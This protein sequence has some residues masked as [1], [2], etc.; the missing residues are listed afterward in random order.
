MN[1]FVPRLGGIIAAACAL[2]G[3]TS[4]AT[5]PSIAVSGACC[6][7][8]GSCTVTTLQ[9][10]TLLGGVYSDNAP[11]P[12]PPSLCDPRAP[13]IAMSRTA[14][15]RLLQ[16]GVVHS[17]WTAGEAL[18]IYN[19]TASPIAEMWGLLDTGAIIAP[20]IAL[21][22]RDHPD[23]ELAAQYV[24]DKVQHAK[25][26]WSTGEYDGK[27]FYWALRLDALGQSTDWHMGPGV[28]P[29]FTNHQ[30][31]VVPG[32]L[33]SQRFINSFTDWG[34]LGRMNAVSATD[35]T[36]TVA[37]TG[38]SDGFFAQYSEEYYLQPWA[39][40]V[41][42]ESEPDMVI[43]G[44]HAEPAGGGNWTVT[45]TVDPPFSQA[46]GADTVFRV[47]RGHNND[48][49]PCYFFKNGSKDVETWMLA[50][51]A[52]LD[53]GIDFPDPV[54]VIVGTEDIGE[55]PVDWENYLDY[56][57]DARASASAEEDPFDPDNT[58]YTIDGERNLA[59]WH[60]D[61]AYRNRDPQDPLFTGDPLTY[62][63]QGAE[64]GPGN[65]D[66]HSYRGATFITAYNYHREKSTWAPLRAIWPNA[67][68]T[69]YLVGDGYGVTDPVAEEVRPV[70]VGPGES[71]YHGIPT[72]YGHMN[73]DAYYCV[74][75]AVIPWDPLSDGRVVPLY[76][77]A[78]ESTTGTVGSG[79]TSDAIVV[80][81]FG[82][83]PNSTT[84]FDP[85]WFLTAETPLFVEFTSGYNIG[86]TVVV[87][88]WAGGA[89][90]LP[91]GLDLL[92]APLNGDEFIVYYPTGVA[93]QYL[94]NNT[95]W[96]LIETFCE[97]YGE[98][99]DAAGFLATGKKWAREQ[100]RAQTLALPESAYTLTI[101]PGP[102]NGDPEVVSRWATYP[103]EPFTSKDGWLDGDDW[104]EVGSQA[105]D[106]GV[107]HF[108]WF[109]PGVVDSG[110]EPHAQLADHMVTAIGA[111]HEHHLASRLHYRE[112]WCLAD[113]NLDGFISFSDQSAFY[114]DF[115]NRMP[116]TDLNGDSDFTDADIDLF[117]SSGDCGL[118]HFV[119]CNGNNR[120]DVLDIA[121]G[122]ADPGDGF[123]DID[124]NDNGVID[125]CEPC[126][127]DWD[128]DLVVGVPDIFAFLSDWF[129]EE[130]GARCYGGT[131]GT[132]AIFAFL[133]TWFS[134]GQ[135][136]CY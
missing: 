113:W 29:A 65:A 8:N 117:Y 37:L 75:N 22:V 93:S 119:D 131:C 1:V 73:W 11:C 33:S 26:E 61:F 41:M 49:R 74:T 123:P 18:D 3:S 4:A 101:G 60:N 36:F 12:T 127:A 27:P 34:H 40:T 9:A 42:V 108:D 98:D 23:P 68:L 51:C 105:I 92:F 132:P 25:S 64:W 91:D 67:K 46:H 104:A 39:A 24:I 58:G 16:E 97:R 55:V 118:P 83:L 57:S 50:F 128:G 43:T 28:L 47:K 107:N 45:F 100:A 15:R 86:T 56:W 48:Y 89:L 87:T 44:Y 69:Q 19:S 32:K 109:V 133:S 77:H 38:D 20:H 85:S 72:W 106:Y 121:E 116:D 70:P 122:D 53:E 54:A 114:L 115:T 31:D 6:V 78:A 59:Q 134:Y 14:A 135:G 35:D 129:A 13:G 99:V 30:A 79:S 2:T 63:P 10:C 94:I 62:T 126:D 81:A 95:P 17:L 125:L 7:A 111:M 52:Y 103:N 136:P 80:A 21:D 88:G 71:V 84:P 124:T 66:I 96:P 82:N 5:P 110:G 130:P 90:L 76:Q 102:Y 120:D 112:I